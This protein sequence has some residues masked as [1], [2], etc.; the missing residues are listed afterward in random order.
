[1]TPLEDLYLPKE[2][3]CGLVVVLV[4]LVV[5]VALTIFGLFCG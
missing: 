1:M 4:V 3:T 2:E 5:L